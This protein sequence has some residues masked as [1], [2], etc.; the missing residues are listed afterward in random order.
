MAGNP[1]V[2]AVALVLSVLDELE[3]KHYAAVPR[4]TGDIDL[5]A[6]LKV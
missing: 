1:I 4:Y 2:R 6:D 5:V 3:I